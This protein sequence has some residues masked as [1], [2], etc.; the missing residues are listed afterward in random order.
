MIE[1]QASGTI[2]VG[3]IDGY[4]NQSDR[5]T[6]TS[7]TKEKRYGISRNTFGWGRKDIVPFE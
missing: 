1:A 4:Y 3:W 6:K 2:H 7:I 5:L